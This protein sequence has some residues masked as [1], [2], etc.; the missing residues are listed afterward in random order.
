MDDLDTD[1]HCHLKNNQVSSEHLYPRHHLPPGHC[2]QVH[3][4][5][6]L[7]AIRLVR[8]RQA[9]NLRFCSALVL[10]TTSNPSL[11]LRC[12]TSSPSSRMP[13][14]LTREMFISSDHVKIAA[15]RPTMFKVSED[16]TGI[17]QVPVPE[18]VRETVKETGILPDGYS[19]G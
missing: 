16:G 6:M 8:H 1:T 17:T 18:S 7:S 12:F 15:A 5:K 9:L 14:P 2:Q 3:H 19:V 10:P 11:Y 4:K 13:T